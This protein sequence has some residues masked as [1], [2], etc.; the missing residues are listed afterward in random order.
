MLEALPA[1]R[2]RLVGP[3]RL[4]ARLG[5]GGMG[6]VHLACRTDTPTADPRHMV[7]VKT[8]RAD[9]EL[10]DDFRARFRREIT[11]ARAV[12]SPYAARLVA[13]D[14]DAA[15]PWLATEYVPG[16]SLAEA[17]PRTGPLP[18]A[19]VTRLGGTLVRALAAVH[20]ARVLHRDLKPANV[21]LG[22]DGPKL[23]DF[24]I[25]QAF[26]A[27]ALTSTGLVV[28]SPG[29]MSP[30]H[31]TG[32]RAV[33]PASDVFCLGA[34]LAFAA[35]GRGPFHDDEMAAVI[36]R[37][38]RADAELSGVPEELR[39]LLGRCLR[40]DPARRPT[41]AELAEEWPLLGD[42]EPFPWPGGVLGLIAA[43]GTA[44][45]ESGEAAA[46]GAG[47][48]ELPTLGPVVPYSPTAVGDRPA[49]GAAGADGADGADGGVGTGAA[50]GRRRRWRRI[51]AAAVAVAVIATVGVILN[52]RAGQGGSGGT[53]GAAGPSA[54]ASRSG[55]P[56]GSASASP[57][58]PG[59]AR[60]LDQVVQ[61]YGGEG[62]TGDFG[63][64]GT[65]TGQRPAGWSPW[66]TKTD[67]DV[68]EC[69][70]APTVLLCAGGGGGALALN[71][72]DGK[73]LWSVPPRRTTDGTNLYPTS[74]YPAV[75]GDT[76]YITGEGVLTA[77]GLK[78][79]KERGRL[80][81]PAGWAHKGTE[82]HDDVLYTSYLR[83]GDTASGLVRAVRLD[84]K[85][86]ARELWRH[87]LDH[88]PEEVVASGGRVFLTIGGV[89]P[90]S[91]DAATGRELAR[92]ADGVECPSLA[93]R[94]ESV[95][96][97]WTRLDGGLPVLDA[98]TLR[99]QRVLAEGV[100]LSGTPAVRADG[101]VAVLSK[102]QSGSATVLTYD[103]ATGREL[104]RTE[105]GGLAADPALV[106]F[107]GDLLVLAGKQD[108]QTLPA[109]ATAADQDVRIRR[110][111]V[112]DG[113]DTNSLT[114]P[115][116]LVAGG[117]V[118]LPSDQVVLSGYLP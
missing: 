4:L 58:G 18:L 79:G 83:L 46:S 16:P 113:V 63:K 84:G 87:P 11:A 7:A 70:L 105:P 42:G 15:A 59:A 38:S 92:G 68:E 80:A 41:L 75:V 65:D 81:A 29:F 116:V 39:P 5:A 13:A 49:P 51:A 3:Y 19:A 96:C 86:G 30:E 115:S 98:R 20:G 117:A 21:L 100:E 53:G 17:V 45:R 57:S 109:S 56:S 72:A 61:P 104:R 48:A 112:P 43:Y 114:T 28:G 40:L 94:G 93:V 102:P 103:L 14:A 27:T 10:D 44:A 35:S 24:G 67:Q 95:L 55:S 78:D 60:V 77:Y 110:A 82:L 12:D 66:A 90:V 64:A 36:Y 74:G 73:K 52:Q 23:I 2:P 50:E 89:V 9:L 107:A 6:E 25:A 1:G 8:V 69:A 101:T 32:S 47:V 88:N 54:S 111:L 62:R 31:L 97:G 33:V 91:L 26:E 106:R 118:F 99:R 22:P 34:A 108:V 37:I 71:A 76:A 85:G